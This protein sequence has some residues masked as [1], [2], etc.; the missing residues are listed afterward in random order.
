MKI[1]EVSEDDCIKAL[2]SQ[3]TDYEDAVIQQAAARSGCDYIV[4]R[5]L[6]D[7][8]FSSVPAISPEEFVE[9]ALRYAR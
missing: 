5:N 4:T 2:G 7:Y 6:R 3:I 9:R 1:L 8:E